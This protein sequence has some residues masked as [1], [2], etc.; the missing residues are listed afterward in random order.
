MPRDPGAPRL[1]EPDADDERLYLVPPEHQRR[2]LEALWKPVPAAGFAFDRDAAQRELV[3]VA[4]D[5][6]LRDFEALGELAG[7]GAPAASQQLGRW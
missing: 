5:G 2:N 3:D 1:D 7:R 6:A 4:V